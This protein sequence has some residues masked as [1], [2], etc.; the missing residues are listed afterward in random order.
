VPKQHVAVPLLESVYSS[1]DALTL[2]SP[3]TI[4]NIECYVLLPA[5]DP[6]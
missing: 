4:G 1:S 6:A 5:P 2:R 3:T